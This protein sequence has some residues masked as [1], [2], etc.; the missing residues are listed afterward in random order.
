[1]KYEVTVICTEIVSRTYRVQADSEEAA[2]AKFSGMAL[3][4]EGPGCEL[5]DISDPSIESVEIDDVRVAGEAEDD[6]E[7]VVAD[8]CDDCGQR[9]HGD[10]E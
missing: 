8:T 4:D 6:D 1:M 2:R 9:H 7:D 10:C 5:S 3:P